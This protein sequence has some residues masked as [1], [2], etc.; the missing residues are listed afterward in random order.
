MKKEN[1]TNSTN[2]SRKSKKGLS[3]VVRWFWYIFIAGVV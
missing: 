3:A 1:S 2:S